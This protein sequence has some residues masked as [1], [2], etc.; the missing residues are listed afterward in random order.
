[1]VQAVKGPAGHA[2]A[3]VVGP[4][5]DEGVE[6]SDE[7]GERVPKRERAPGRYLDDARVLR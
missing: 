5:P 2:D 6:P 7:R 1:M 4:A 3:E